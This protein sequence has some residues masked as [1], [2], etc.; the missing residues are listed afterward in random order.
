MNI[1]ALKL[2]LPEILLNLGASNVVVRDT[3]DFSGFYFMVEV[4]DNEAIYEKEVFINFRPPRQLTLPFPS[5]VNDDSV[6]E[7]NE[8][9]IG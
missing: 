3:S 8:S 5:R 4:Q 9:D 2:I 1:D 7:D 6:E